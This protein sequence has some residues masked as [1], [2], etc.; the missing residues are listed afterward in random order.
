MA[1]DDRPRAGHIGA[2]PVDEVESGGALGAGAG[3]AASEAVGDGRRAEVAAETVV[4]EVLLEALVAG[5]CL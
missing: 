3:A 1:V 4:V 5:E 2:G